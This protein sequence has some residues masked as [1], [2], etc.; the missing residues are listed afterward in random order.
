M[1]ALTKLHLFANQVDILA[2]DLDEIKL[3][4]GKNFDEDDLDTII[5]LKLLAGHGKFGK[6]TEFKKDIS[7]ELM[8]EAGHHT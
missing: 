8:P 2:V 3:D 7:K 5:N 6:S 4:D 1:K